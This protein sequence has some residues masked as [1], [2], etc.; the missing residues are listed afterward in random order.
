[1]GGNGEGT[2][3]AERNKRTKK[4]KEN[5]VLYLIECEVSAA[6]GPLGRQRA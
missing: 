3:R 6:T 4:N 1:M 5:E 2:E